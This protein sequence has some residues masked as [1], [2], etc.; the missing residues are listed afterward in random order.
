MRKI[1]I[2]ENVERNNENMKFL[3]EAFC[4]DG[5]IKWQGYIE[6]ELNNI[7]Y[8]GTAY[9]LNDSKRGTFQIIQSKDI[10]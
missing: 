9:E 8:I 3:K 4:I 2:K 7:K 6:Y 5:N 10:K 1:S